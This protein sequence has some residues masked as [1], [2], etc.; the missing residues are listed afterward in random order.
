MLNAPP[1]VCHVVTYRVDH[2]W[3]A[4][5]AALHWSDAAHGEWKAAQYGKL[6]RRAWRALWCT[7]ADLNSGRLRIAVKVTLAAFIPSLAVLVPDLRDVL[8]VG[9]S[10]SI[11]DYGYWAAMTAPLVL[12]TS[13][14]ASYLRG[15]L[16]VSGT[17]AGAALS[18][19]I[20]VPTLWL[21]ERA[22]PFVVAALNVLLVMGFSFFRSSERYAFFGATAQLTTQVVVLGVARNFSNFT[23]SD[24]HFI[25]LSRMLQNVIG[26]VVAFL[27][28]NLLWPLHSRKQLP[29]AVSHA[30]AECQFIFARVLH[31]HFRA[32][33]RAHRVLYA[34]AGRGEQQSG[35]DGDP[36]GVI[37]DLPNSD[38]INH[39]RILDVDGISSRWVPSD[40]DDARLSAMQ[41]VRAVSR[42]HDVQQQVVRLRTVR[43]LDGQSR[44]LQRDVDALVVRGYNDLSPSQIS[45]PWCCSHCM[46]ILAF[47]LS[48]VLCIVIGGADHSNAVCA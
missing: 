4:I 31:G 25:I 38:Y 24:A 34:K 1:P 48:V 29:L 35:G 14:G 11:V 22:Y 7:A 32:H 17:I 19:P 12:E 30:I 36:N 43:V 42:R 3:C 41:S 8:R 28:A 37:D 20:A 9:A 2:R 15:L 23:L 10:R 18:Y 33:A 26:V 27:I 6:I 16:R 40:V 39:S 44:V 13:V 46:M 47:S 45:A 5:P 21:P